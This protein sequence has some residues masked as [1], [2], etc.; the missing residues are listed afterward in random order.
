M[1]K[2]LTI[3]L[4]IDEDV[5]A[6]AYGPSTT[7]AEDINNTVPALVALELAEAFERRGLVVSVGVRDE[8]GHSPMR[9][10]TF[11]GHWDNDEIVVEWATP[12]VVD[13]DR[14][15][16]GYWE[17]GLWCDSGEGLTME[18]AQAAA[19]APYEAAVTS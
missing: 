10:W 1:I 3:N 13:D 18:Q 5:W 4:D 7:V 12:G 14:I 8:T 15:D 9:T 16:T 6:T 19:V 2:R 17:Q 11:F